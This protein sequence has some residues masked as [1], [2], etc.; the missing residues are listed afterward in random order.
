MRERN[1][2]FLFLAGVKIYA[3]LWFQD[4]NGRASPG[5]RLFIGCFLSRGAMVSPRTG[6]VDNA[7]QFAEARLERRLSARRCLARHAGPARRKRS[8]QS[9]R[10]NLVLATG[11][12]HGTVCR[13]AAAP[14]QR[15]QPVV[16]LDA[17]GRTRVD[18]A[19]ALR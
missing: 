6:P 7:E 13:V 5:S 16:Q 15:R 4:S 18:P 8:E 19:S 9:D 3:S 11:L 14:H 1:P 2:G 12:A 10:R 17:F